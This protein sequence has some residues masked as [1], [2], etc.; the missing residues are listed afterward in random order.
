MFSHIADSRVSDIMCKSLNLPSGCHSWVQRGAK[1]RAG[2]LQPLQPMV[3]SSASTLLPSDQF[4]S[5]APLQEDRQKKVQ[6][7]VWKLIWEFEVLKDLGL[8]KGLESCPGSQTYI[9]KLA[10]I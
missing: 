8:L 4:L 5:S 10:L 6:E 3:V 1:E 9:N 2:I 7:H